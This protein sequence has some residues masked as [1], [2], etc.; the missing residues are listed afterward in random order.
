MITLDPPSTHA[1]L[2][3]PQKHLPP[4]RLLAL[5]GFLR[6]A[7]HAVGIPGPVSV[8]LTRDSTLRRLNREFRGQDRPTDVLSFPAAPAPEAHPPLKNAHA[9]Y[10]G[11]L[12]ISLD[13][14]ARQA[15]RLQHSL[16]TEVRIL[17]L[18]G[19]LHLAGE[20]HETDNGEMAVREETLRRRFRLPTAL[21]ARSNEVAAKARPT[22]HPK[23]GD[24]R[25]AQHPS[26]PR[27]SSSR[28]RGRA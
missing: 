25:P 26:G 22:P 20:D 8:L 10:A 5:R 13:T 21:I 24:T 16:E 23:T 28:P 19:L 17:L 15:R 12:A 14:A 4:P 18:H 7:R 1:A 11:D 6:R 27:A 9:P 2:G 3:G